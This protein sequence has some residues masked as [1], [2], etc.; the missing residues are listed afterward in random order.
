[1]KKIISVFLSVVLLLLTGCSKTNTENPSDSTAENITTHNPTVTVSNLDFNGLDDPNLC[2]Y[3]N[4]VVYSDLVADLNSENYFVENVSSVYISKEYLEEIEY[5]SKENIYFGYTYTQLN[6]LFDGDRFLITVDDNGKTV[7]KSYKDFDRTF[8]KTVIK[9][10]AIGTGVILVCVTVSV[11]TAGTGMAAV[12]AVFAASAKTGTAF[13]LSSGTLSALAAG[14]VTGTETKDMDAALREAALKGSESFKW[15]AIS[16]SILGGGKELIALKGATLN[17]LTLNEAAAIQKESGYPLDVIKRFKSVDEYNV[18]KDAG[19]YPKM[20]N[21]K[22]ALIRDIDWNYTK[23]NT[24]NYLRA[25]KGG[26]P[27]EPLSG[28]SY[29]V[30]HINQDPNGTFAILTEKEHLENSKILHIF[31]K[32][33]TIDRGEFSKE[34]IKFWKACAALVA[35]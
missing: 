13:A 10:L 6:E 33:S 34:K 28:K 25:L 7:A 3:I 20:V 18:Y 30:H 21:G 26:P 4:N 12:S 9:N 1:M 22:I 24:S 19:L 8:E 32:E 31:G 11:T 23:D 15:G 29:Q 16:G 2:T 27:I 14:I 17:G 5:N 35:A